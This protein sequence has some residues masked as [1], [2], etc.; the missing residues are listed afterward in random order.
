MGEP[1]ALPGRARERDDGRDPA[2]GDRY[3]EEEDP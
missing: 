2:G 1:P 3:R